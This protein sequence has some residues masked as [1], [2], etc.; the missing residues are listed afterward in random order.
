MK[1][2]SSTVELTGTLSAELVSMLPQL[3]VQA[4]VQLGDTQARSAALLGLPELVTR[5]CFLVV[6][7]GTQKF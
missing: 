3:C 5:C 2:V 4:G 1:Q 6:L 7:R